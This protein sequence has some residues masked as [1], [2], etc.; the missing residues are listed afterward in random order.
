MNK[1]MTLTC[2]VLMVGFARAEGAIC[3]N[4]NLLDGE[5]KFEEVCEENVTSVE[6]VM[7]E[8]TLRRQLSVEELRY[9]QDEGGTD[10]VV[11]D[12]GEFSDKFEVLED[13]EKAPKPS[14]VNKLDLAQ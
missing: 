13:T 14:L 1:A 3:Q 5:I 6:T 11:T 8:Y 7:D 9:L 12:N 4:S 2:A 10:I